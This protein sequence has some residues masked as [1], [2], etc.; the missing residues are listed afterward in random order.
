[1][2]ETSRNDIESLKETFDLISDHVIITDP[3]ARIIYANKSV[4]AQTGYAPEEIIGKNPGKIWGG[5]MPR[6]FYDDMWKTI[7]TDKKPFTGEVKNKRK[8]GT[9]YWQEMRIFPV[10]DD[11]KNIKY[12]IGIEPNIE[13]KK[14]AEETLRQER[15]KLEILLESIGDGVVAIDPDWNIIIWNK[16][17][18]QISGWTREE[19]LGKS[20][21]NFMHFVK[22]SSRSENISFIEDAMI[23]GKTY[24]MERHTLLIKKDGSEIPVGD[25]AAPILDH[26][27]R[28]T[29]VII[30]FRDISKEIENN[31]LRADFVYASHQLNTPISKV[32]WNLESAKSEN[33][34]IRLKEKITTAYESALSLERLT[35]ELQVISKID[36][37]LI[38]LT[39][40]TVPIKEIIDTVTNN[41]SDLSKERSVAVV[42]KD[43]PILSIKTDK[44][45]IERALTEVLRNAL[46][47]SSV[48]QSISVRCK[49]Q[50]K[51]LIISIEDS[52]IGITDE[53]QTI[54]F[55]KFF[56]GN[57]FNTTQ[58]SGS[59]LGLSI[60]KGYI[61]VLKGRIWFD[62]KPGKGTVFYI[63]L[64]L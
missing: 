51:D 42:V 52:G 28:I 44:N 58:I 1:M 22:E 35:D 17:A 39:I 30:V 29:G 11:V 8:D 2:A 63:S 23:S 50:D 33:D 34:P 13:A 46:I 57:N 16:A 40:V 7:K 37:K 43:V 9:E 45:F 41:L 26:A 27:G 38:S 59:G 64:P 18:T 62:S 55:T 19:A 20:F 56:R 61:T 47:Y 3:D 31:R 49:V 5:N 25:S 53:Q 10:L 21:R 6:E 14:K 36:Q 15:N 54:V 48:S 4:E 32:L 12:F 24:S 60:A